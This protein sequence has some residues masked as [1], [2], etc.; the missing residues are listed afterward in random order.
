M[1]QLVT[2]RTKSYLVFVLIAILVFDDH[3]ASLGKKASQKLNS[4]TRAAQYMNLEQRR[5]IMKAFICSQFGYCPLV[6]MFHSRKMNNRI[7][8]LLERA[9]RVVYRDYNATFSELLSKDESV[10]NLQSR[11]QLLAKNELN[12]KIM[13]EIFKFKKMDY[14]L[15][16]N[17]ENR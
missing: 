14:N 17:T 6:W 4:L 5:S 12:P 15:R 16:N 13:E 1:K 9:L 3:V 7:N 11:L 2:A 8:N 10:T